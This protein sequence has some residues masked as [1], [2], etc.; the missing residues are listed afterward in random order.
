MLPGF[1]SLLRAFAE[2]VVRVGIHLQ[3]GQ[4]PPDEAVLNRSLV[5]VDLSVDASIIL[6]GTEPA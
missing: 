6:P 3:R 4:R 1:E 2:G 5:H